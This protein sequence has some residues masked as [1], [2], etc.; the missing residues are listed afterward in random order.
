MD[1]IVGEAHVRE[2]MAAVA[3]EAYAQNGCADGELIRGVVVLEPH[4]ETGGHHLHCAIWCGRYHKR[5]DVLDRARAADARVRGWKRAPE[6]EEVKVHMGGKGAGRYE[7]K[8]KEKEGTGLRFHLNLAHDRRYAESDAAVKKGSKKANEFKCRWDFNEMVDYLL[9]P[10]KEKVI[11]EAPLF[12]NC[13]ADSIFVAE[14]EDANFALELT[15]Y[16]REMKAEGVNRGEARERLAD[17][18]GC[19]KDCGWMVSHAMGAYNDSHTNVIVEYLPEAIQDGD[20]ATARQLQLFV[21]LFLEDGPCREGCGLWLQSPAGTGKTTIA[22]LLE[23]RYPNQVYFGLERGATGSH[24]RTSLQDYDF[25][26]HRIMVFNDVKGKTNAT[27]KA[28][29]PRATHKLFRE[30]TDGV[31]MP[32]SWGMKNYTVTPVAKVFIN[33][34]EDPPQDVEFLRRYLWVRGGRDGEVDIVNPELLAKRGTPAKNPCSVKLKENL[35]PAACFLDRLGDAAKSRWL[36]REKA[37]SKKAKL[38]TPKLESEESPES[39]HDV[40]S[41][42]RPFD[43]VGN[44]CYLNATLQGMFA[45]APVRQLA[46]A[47]V[48]LGDAD[49]EILW[50]TDCFLATA[51]AASLRGRDPMVPERLLARFHDGRQ[52]DAH[53]FLQT[54][55]LDSASAPRMA[56]LCSGRD[57]PVL[58]CAH[59]GF[60]RGAAAEDFQVLSLSIFDAGAPLRSVAAALDQYLAPERV[61]LRQWSCES[62]ACVAQGAHRDDPVKRHRIAIAPEILVVHLAPIHNQTLRKSSNTR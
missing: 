48:Q 47:L 52:H 42:P 7:L 9:A 46:T 53:E 62:L 13:D 61:V 19:R 45:A 57:E 59:C 8:Q 26:R 4:A 20:L 12:I 33:S 6:Y 2:H 11:D 51:C 17:K 38:E 24:D 32:F 54:K 39:G 60:R 36:R 31:P 5:K 22:K 29:F 15:R 58:E 43:N 44:S 1:H 3:M 18:A 27:G 41:R 16:A 37:E 56:R 55:L 35:R 10:A 21:C 49:A 28:F 40:C 50:S 25:G 30:I 23:V 34:T 14:E